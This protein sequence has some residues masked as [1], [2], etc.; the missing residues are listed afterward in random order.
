[1]GIIRRGGDGGRRSHHPERYLNGFLSFI[2]WCAS[3]LAAGSRPRTSR[4]SSRTRAP[5]SPG[6]GSAGTLPAGAR[7]D[8]AAD[9]QRGL[10]PEAPVMGRMEH[11]AAGIG[12][13]ANQAGQPHPGGRP[14]ADHL[15]NHEDRGACD[16]VPAPKGGRRHP[17]VPEAPGRP[18]RPGWL[19]VPDQGGKAL[20]ARRGLRQ[21][22][23]EGL[24][25]R[26]GAGRGR[27]AAPGTGRGPR[28][29]APAPDPGRSGPHRPG[30][31]RI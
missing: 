23:Q 25:Q 9:R 11:R 30:L 4:I 1:M 28:T 24:Q 12:R 18:T 13:A 7:A 8:H 20:Q 16:G 10:A 2:N 14:G 21:P 26:E 15:R 29:P 22:E 27:S 6:T 5:G 31:G 17:G 3:P 19:P